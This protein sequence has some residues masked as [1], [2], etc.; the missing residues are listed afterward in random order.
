MGSL[1]M[2]VAQFLL[3]LKTEK[4][5]I[6]RTPIK[7]SGK[8]AHGNRAE[9]IECVAFTY[10]PSGPFD[11]GSG[12][13]TGRRTHSPITIVREVDAASPLLWQALCSNEGFVTATLSFA[14]PSPGGNN[15]GVHTIELTNGF[16]AKVVGYHGA[17]R[18]AGKR[19]QKI[20]LTYESIKVN[21]LPD[22]II[23]RLMMMT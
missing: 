15:F 5:G 6:I 19:W 20:T 10:E 1:R 16:V 9:G 2:P 13:A 8:G 3:T 11:S 17:G 7:S 21:G 12:Q 4:Q 22:G 23:P 14:R 18:A